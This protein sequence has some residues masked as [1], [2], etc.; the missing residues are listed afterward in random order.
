MTMLY[1]LLKGIG[2]KR[3]MSARTG[4]RNISGGHRTSERRISERKS[5]FSGLFTKH[6]G[7]DLKLLATIYILLAFGLIMIMSASSA[8]AL[9][10]KNDSLYFFKRQ[11]L[12][13]I[14]GSFGMFFMAKIDYHKLQ[15]YAGVLWISSLLLLLLVLIPG[16]GKIVNDA[17]RWIYIGPISFQPSEI[18]K[19]T[20]IIFFSRFLVLNQKN[21][22]KFG[23]GL[24]LYLVP[25]GVVAALIML[26]PHFSCTMLIV[27]TAMILFFIAGMNTKHIGVIIIIAVLGIAG[28]IILE[29][30]RMAR[31]TTF[32]D[33]F[34]D[35]Q[36]KGYQIIQSLYAIG[37]GRF[38][39]LGLGLGRQK[40]SYLPEPQNDFI[41]SV[42]CEELGFVGAL[43][44]IAL[45]LYFILRGIKIAMSAPDLFGT[46][47]ASGITFLMALQVFINIGV[48]SAAIPVTGMPLPFFSY[49][50]TSLAI[51][52]VAMG[53]MLNISRSCKKKSQ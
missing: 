13:M 31:V 51:T 18:A 5:F 6:G 17:R 52:M 35:P 29:P 46:L 42:I 1:I 37:S 23:K 48:V 26:E 39:G 47:L 44:V 30:Y 15:Q 11:F 53:I 28:M 20:S 9:V 21:I 14:V 25:I 2:R 49:G 41:F 12:W 4:Q 8:V 45:F 24:C 22:K 38:S 27:M 50:G 34:T 33:P 36:G 3:S 19:I 10:G 7:V 32:L 43:V 40:Y 16:I